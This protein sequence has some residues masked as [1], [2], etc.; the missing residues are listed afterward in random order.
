MRHC[1]F[2]GERSERL[3]VW[4]DHPCFYL[5][6][7]FWYVCKWV[8]QSKILFMSGLDHVEYENFLNILMDFSMYFIY[9]IASLCFYDMIHET[10]VRKS[11]LKSTFMNLII[12]F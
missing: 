9:L 7:L 5:T 6:Q 12:S 1:H 4:T 8:G 3:P 2:S 11:E 10:V